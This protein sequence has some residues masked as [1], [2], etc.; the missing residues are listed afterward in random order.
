MKAKT[1]APNKGVQGTLHKVS[2]P[3]TRDVEPKTIERLR[4]IATAAATAIKIHLAG[5]Y[6]CPATAKT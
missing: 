5:V 4:E 6:K 1:T 2:G 3:L